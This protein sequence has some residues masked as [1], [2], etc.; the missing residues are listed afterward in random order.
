MFRCNHVWMIVVKE[1][2]P[3]PMGEVL[4]RA[5]GECQIN[6]GDLEGRLVIILA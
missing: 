2:F 4:G 1:N 3:S 6:G 5:V